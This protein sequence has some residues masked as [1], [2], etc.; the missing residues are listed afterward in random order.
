MLNW[1][2]EGMCVLN[3]GHVFDRTRI[4]TDVCMRCGK[5]VFISAQE[6]NYRFLAQIMPQ[7]EPIMEGLKK[8]LREAESAKPKITQ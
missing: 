5:I 2:I 6:Q 8:L 1:L 7:L 4:C 3:G